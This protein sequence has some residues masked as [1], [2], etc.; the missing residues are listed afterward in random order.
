MLPAVAAVTITQPAIADCSRQ[1]AACR[2]VTMPAMDW[3]Q[4]WE[5]LSYIVTVFGLP[6]AIYIFMTERRKERLNDEEEIYLLL[7]DAYADF[8]KLV[9]A[10]PDLRLLSKTATPD[11]TEE[12]QERVLALLEMLVSVFERAYLLEY[13][14][15]MSA[16]QLRR[17]RSWEDYMREW[18]RREDFRGR[19]PQLLQG[20]DA[21]FAA[22]FSRLAEEE[23][24]AVVRA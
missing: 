4:I 8:L 23:S 6:L 21:D 12:Q 24:R 19:L 9:I 18:C 22:Y 2:R 15:R 1:A 13:E 5:L 3:L 11:L 16:S 7:S 10:N 17:W 20:E 14:E